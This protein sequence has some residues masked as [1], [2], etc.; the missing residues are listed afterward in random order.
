[1]WWLC[2]V[3]LEFAKCKQFKK[4]K[5]RKKEKETGYKNPKRSNKGIHTTYPYSGILLNHSLP[6]FLFLFLFVFAF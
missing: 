4:K 6:L 5:E 3:G 2:V 1:M